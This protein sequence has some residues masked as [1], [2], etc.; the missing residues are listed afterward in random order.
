M[1]N[2]TA[3]KSKRFYCVSLI[4]DI[5]KTPIG[6]ATPPIPYSIIGEFAD[7]TG[8]SPN[9]KSLGDPVILFQCSTIP[10]VK[11]D[12]PGTAGGIKSGTFGKCVETKTSSKTLRANGTATVQEGCEVWMNNRNTIGK[13]YER[14][15]AVPRTRLQQLGAW[16]GGQAVAA[17]ADA[18]EAL[19]PIAQDYKDNASASLHQYGADAMEVGG[20][21]IVGSGVVGVAG[22]VVGATGIG[23]PVAAAMESGAAAGSAVGRAVTVAGGVAETSATVLDQ[24]ADFIL[25][26]K[27]PGM[28]QAVMDTGTRLLESAAMAKLGNLSKWIKFPTLGQLLTTKPG[29]KARHARPLA[30]PPDKPAGGKS[31]GK[32]K[33]SKADKPSDCCPKNSAPGGKPVAGRK[34]VH[35]GTGEEVLYQTDFVLEGPLPLAWTRCY[36]SGSEHQ[37]WGLLGARWSSPFMSALLLVDKGVVYVDDSGRGL[38]L[39]K[40]AIGQSFDSRSEGFVLTRS[41]ADRFQLTWRDGSQETFVRDTGAQDSWLPHGY[42]GVNAMH[43]PGLAVHA[44]RF[45][46]RSAL[47]RDGSGVSIDRYT[48]VQPEGL[49]LRVRSTDGRVLEA[50]QT[51]SSRHGSRI[52]HVDEVRPDGTRICHVRYDYEA[53]PATL[54]A[55]LPADAINPAQRFNLVSQ[56]DIAGHV[57]RYRYRHHLLESCTS[58][59]GFTHTINWISLTELREHW[60]GRVDAP[61]FPITLDNSYQARAIATAGED[62]SD[63]LRIDYPTRDTTRV[64]DAVG[65]TLEY[66]FNEQWLA[67]EVRRISSDGGAASLGR[68]EWDRDGMLLAEIDAAGH[69]TRYTYDAAGNLI[70]SADALGR[71]SSIEYDAHNQAITLTDPVGSITRLRYDANGRIS[72]Y[73]DALG[74]ATEY[75]YDASGRLMEMQD[76]KGGIKRFEYDAAGRLTAYTDCSGNRSQYKYDAANRLAAAIDAQYHET[77]YEY[78][79]LGRLCRVIQPDDSADA[80]VYDADGNLLKHIDALGFSTT[81]RYNGQGLP[82][83]RTDALG[84]TVGYG[85]D[86][87]LR[88]VELVN[89]N[90]ESYRLDYNAEGWLIAETGFDGKTSNYSYDSSGQLK[91]SDC[92]GQHIGLQRDVCGQLLAK[93]SADGITRFAYDAAGRL[94]AASAPH[95]EQRFAYDALGQLVEERSA[96]YLTQS[97]ATTG[98]RVPDASFM[99]THAYDELGNRIQTILP[100]GRR[101]DILRYGAG[102]WHG[103]LWQGKQIVAIE[104]DTLHREKVRRIG[105]GAQPLHAERSY[106]PQSR[107]ASITLR[108]SDH[109]DARLLRQRHFS[110]DPVG[111]LLAIQHGR[112]P[113][114]DALGTYRYSY[115][116]IGQLLS[117]IQPG[118]SEKF[119][120]DPAGNLIDTPPSGGTANS[121]SLTGSVIPVGSTR[122]TQN[123]P[124]SYKGFS[125]RYDEH[126]NV[127][128]KRLDDGELVRS[129]WN[130]DLDYDSEN[131]LI[132]AFR[133][134]GDAR[135]TSTY[136]YD[137]FSRRIAKI[138][139]AESLSVCPGHELDASTSDEYSI[140]FVWDGDSIVQEF[141]CTKTISYL[142]EPGTFVPLARVESSGGHGINIQ[143][144]K[145]IPEAQVVGYQNIQI[146]PIEQWS[147][148]SE[149]EVFDKSDVKLSESRSRLV[150]QEIISQAEFYAANDL[151]SNYVC[152]HI[153]TPREI[154]DAHGEIIQEF[155]YKAWG[156]AWNCTDRGDAVDTRECENWQKIRFQG[157]LQDDETGLYY[158]R[159]R[160]YDPDSASYTSQ[161]PIRLLGGINL[162]RYT[163]NPVNEIDPTGLA[164]CRNSPADRAQDS[165]GRWR[166]RDGRFAKNPGWPPNY[167]FAAGKDSV[168]TLLPGSKIDRFGHPGGE[169]VSPAGTPFG[170][171]ALPDVSFKKDYHVYEV[172][173]N[174][175]GV[176]AGP[177]EPWFR[178]VGGG[179]QYQLPQSV[180]SYLASGHLVE[181]P[182]P[183]KPIK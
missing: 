58:Y 152:D 14:G 9:V 21:I 143:R 93:Q 160:Y 66:R 76:A 94:I 92:R 91:A 83:S 37:D 115:D 121:T 77:H 56:T 114:E 57:R 148:S 45:S 47:N 17:G 28:M 159:Y 118:M 25:T 142:F 168:I 104:R 144:A 174:I 167:G 176:R 85:Y 12:E 60:A 119:A 78:D 52:G 105:D 1:A 147:M 120:F 15:G 84:Q 102:H 40:L 171:R 136:L 50:M 140:L 79:V 44:E 134:Q 169:F 48:D 8:V 131:R 177:A 53:E 162:Y 24:A 178:Q 101:I 111:N 80:Y 42:D 130:L 155:R 68:R 62:G 182:N 63:A 30:G 97:L 153:G 29:K 89:G 154:I 132:R 175:P 108:A 95:A 49:L 90:G 4:P 117:A 3:T 146:W 170:Q 69:G 181:I 110:Y 183:C 109:E 33:D 172:V 75:R 112:H 158:N 82:I 65:G 20:N 38:R 74:H 129:A 173:V 156:R 26:G 139:V 157:Q 99:M 13:I 126:G 116:P 163:A 36:R 6:P 61:S 31:K 98:S 124:K 19:K 55:A 165:G 149:R 123:P 86:A 18:R 133:T 59:G 138:V 34:P 103:T 96:Y 128:N 71:T 166:E 27:T 150:W 88:L 5:C 67:V 87:V 135:N 64:T 73:I 54:S 72:A 137:A 46:L 145:K 16:I 113:G 35:F 11:G 179:S 100:N 164:K 125:Y 23:L 180:N 161:D 122:V 32:K 22:V 2:E 39:P 141:N 41:E 51:A 81:Y 10:T 127:V 43:P 107:L 70:S 151:G 7:A 106:D